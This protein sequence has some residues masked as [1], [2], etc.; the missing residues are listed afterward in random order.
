MRSAGILVRNI[1]VPV[2]QSKLLEDEISQAPKNRSL[3]YYFSRI[4][5]LL[6]C[7]FGG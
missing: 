1:H 6:H 7:L 2:Q 4:H 5:C 3:T